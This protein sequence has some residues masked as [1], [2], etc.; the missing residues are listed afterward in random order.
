MLV[1][2][3]RPGSDADLDGVRRIRDDIAG[4][5]RVLLGEVAPPDRATG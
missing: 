3:V 1:D 4:R 2:A 5:V